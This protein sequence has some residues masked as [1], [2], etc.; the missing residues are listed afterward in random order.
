MSDRLPLKTKLSELVLK[1]LS[2]PVI[3]QKPQKG[4]W[5]RLPITE[6][7]SGNDGPFHGSIRIG[8]E[9]KLMVMFHGGGVSWNEHMAARP[10]TIYMPIEGD[11][12]YAL[13][14]DMVADVAT[15]HGISSRKKSCPFRN[16]SVISIP[17]CCGDFHC[18][19]GDFP[20]TALDGS[21][22]V[23]R[24][25]GYLN[26]RAV[27]KKAMKY[28][29][30]APEQIM[31]TGFSA[32]G[33]GTALLTDDVM[34][35]FPECQ[36]VVCYVDSGFMLYDGWRHAAEQVWH[37]PKE[38]CDRLR[39]DDIT[40]DSLQAL[41]AN[42][43]DR[44]KICFS[45]SVRDVALSEYWTFVKEGHLHTD[46]QVGITFQKDLRKMC[47]TMLDTIP[48]AGI[49][50]FN[51]PVSGKGQEQRQ[52]QGLTQHCIGLAGGAKSIR[53][54]GKN[55]MEWIWNA[56]NGGVECVGLHLLDEFPE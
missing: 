46:K 43:G 45:C 27:M 28:I 42:H 29:G 17:Y 19:A 8:T 11:N 50:I 52:E 7:V 30:N 48:D 33:F 14:G 25:H 37:A 22:Q 55:V 39:T 16:W 54:D 47:H 34:G 40:L 24:H 5:Y 23:L 13:D 2:F 56:V 41:K 21:H 53:V 10:N 49:F 51:T 38:I 35:L 9:N 15:G 32:G 18:G 4:K 3:P 20:Y 12:F 44:V 6:C 1:A 26:Y 31:V 36:D